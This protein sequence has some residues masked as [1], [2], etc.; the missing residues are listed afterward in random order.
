MPRRGGLVEAVICLEMLFPELSVI[1]RVDRI[2]AA[3]FSAIEFWGWR[4]KDLAALKA[5]CDRA[6]VRVANFSGHRKGSL[7]ARETHDIFRED[8]RDAVISAKGLGCSTL[9]LLSNEL[10]EGGRVVDSYEGISPERKYASLR[11]GLRSAL[12]A[13]PDGFTLVLEPLNTRIDHPGYFLQDMATAVALVKEIAHPGLKV[14]CD[15]Y[16][17]AVMGEDL[18]GIIDRHADSIGHYHVADVP[19]RHEPGTGTLDWLAL[20]RRI[21]DSGY[22]GTIGFEYAPLGDSAAS[23]D[24]IRKLWERAMA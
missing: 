6:G 4:D 19:G 10:G 24:S 21:R 7:V 13:A 23:L 1:D 5:A 11:E 22:D 8:L 17:L 15:L 20:L 3:G 18:E 16:H 12:D 9:M 14:L 2:A